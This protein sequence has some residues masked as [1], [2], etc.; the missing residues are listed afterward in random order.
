MSGL[1]CVTCSKFY[2]VKKQGVA[3]EEGMPRGGRDGEPE[4]WH[5]YKLWMADLCECPG[6]G[7]Q[8]VMGFGARPIAEH[9]QREYAT[10]R[11]RYAPITRIDDCGGKKP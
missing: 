10:L 2:R 6:C 11:E 4:T 3:V 8:V 7:A 5:P 1:A 9:Y